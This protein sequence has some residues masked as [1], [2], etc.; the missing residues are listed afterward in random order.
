[1]MTMDDDDNNSILEEDDLD[2]DKL[3]GLLPECNEDKLCD[4]CKMQ[5]SFARFDTIRYLEVGEEKSLVCKRFKG[6]EGVEIPLA[7]VFFI[8]SFLI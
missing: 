6:S 2:K 7:Y 5:R 1:M 4:G 3:D 8:G